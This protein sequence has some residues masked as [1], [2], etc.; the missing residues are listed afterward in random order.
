MFQKTEMNGE[1]R[2]KIDG[3]SYVNERA[4]VSIHSEHSGKLFSLFAGIELVK[5]SAI[6]IKLL[7]SLRRMET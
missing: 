1:N 2:R 3:N 7:L 6:R 5:F 4:I